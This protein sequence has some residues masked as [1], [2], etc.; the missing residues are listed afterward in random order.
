VS[1]PTSRHA[2]RRRRAAWRKKRRE[3]EGKRGKLRRELFDRQNE[4]EARRNNL[5][6][7]LEGRLRRQAAGH[8]L[9]SVEWALK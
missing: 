1:P 4:I 6:G 9:F 5:I 3:P 8:T 7:E 2:A